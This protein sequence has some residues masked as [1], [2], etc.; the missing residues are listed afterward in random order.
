MDF[1]LPRRPVTLSLISGK[2]HYESIIEP[3]ANARR[4]VWISTANLKELLV[5]DTRLRPGRSRTRARR[6]YRSVLEVMNELAERGVELRIL[7]A[8]LPS[9]AFRDALD[10]YPRLWKGGLALKMCPR[11]HLKVV[12]VDGLQLYL[13]SANWTGAGLGAKGENRRN[14]ELGVLTEDERWLDA[15]QDLY[16]NIWRGRPCAACKLRNECEAP[17]DLCNRESSSSAGS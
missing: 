3:L 4:S 14:F 9:Q 13:G 15:V 5:A 16:E 1:V 7:H 8:R 6:N 17:L 2:G 11:V 12:I 10:R